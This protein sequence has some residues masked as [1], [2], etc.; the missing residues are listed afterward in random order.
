[1][2][3]ESAT[4][5]LHTYPHFEI[6]LEKSEFTQL[7][8]DQDRIQGTKRLKGIVIDIQVV[9]LLKVR[10]KDQDSHDELYTISG[11]NRRIIA[12]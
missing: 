9:P 10:T 12:N 4:E 2:D 6:P 7:W 5:Q 8:I 3:G 11:V 1:M